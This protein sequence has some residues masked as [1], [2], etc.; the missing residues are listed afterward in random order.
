MLQSTTVGQGIRGLSALHAVARREKHLVRR[1]GCSQRH[2]FNKIFT[3]GT[4]TFPEAVAIS[5]SERGFSPKLDLAVD[6]G[7]NPASR[8]RD[9]MTAVGNIGYLT[10]AKWLVLSGTFRRNA[11]LGSKHRSRETTRRKLCLPKCALGRAPRFLRPMPSLPNCS[12]DSMP[13]FQSATLDF[14]ADVGIRESV[15]GSHRSCERHIRG[16]KRKFAR[17]QRSILPRRCAL[18]KVTVDFSAE[19]GIRKSEGA[20]ARGDHFPRE[21]GH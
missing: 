1:A 21:H 8:R 14:A 5:N 7:S 18:G 9:P 2:K 10:T 19:M 11:R 17:R 6:G 3:P 13:I 4:Q 16:S 20:F 12:A 15:E